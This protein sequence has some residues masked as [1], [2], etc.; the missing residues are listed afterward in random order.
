MPGRRILSLG[1]SSILPDQA[2]VARVLHADVDD[3]RHRDE[4][5]HVPVEAALHPFGLQPQGD[6]FGG[7]AE[8]RVRQ[9][10]RQSDAERA[11]VGG[12]QL[13][14]H[15]RI[16]RGVAGD[17]HQGRQHQRKGGERIAHR[18]QRAENRVGEQHARQAEA[19]HLRAR[20]AVGGKSITHF[21]PISAAC[22]VQRRDSAAP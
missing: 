18:L 16:D 15:H 22:S 9:R 8:Q 5:G 6:I 3:Q 21:A 20:Y 2:V 17:D 14:L 4:P 1:R 19:D 10:V 13:G 7:A 11:D 12:E